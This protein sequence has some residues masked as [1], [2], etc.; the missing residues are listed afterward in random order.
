MVDVARLSALCFVDGVLNRD[1]GGAAPIH[2]N[3]DEDR[4][5]GGASQDWGRHYRKCGAYL[6]GLPRL[7][8]GGEG[9]QKRLEPAVRWRYR[10]WLLLLVRGLRRTQKESRDCR[11]LNR[12]SCT[13]IQ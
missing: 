13:W 5:R 4:L 9:G 12:H 3:P 2:R 7:V 6:S 10:Q 1:L 11:R 8:R